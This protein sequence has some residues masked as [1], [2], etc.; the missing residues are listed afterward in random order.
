MQDIV[1]DPVAGRI[2]MAAVVLGIMI[3]IYMQVRP[4]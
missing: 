4:R 3:G 1:F 2:I